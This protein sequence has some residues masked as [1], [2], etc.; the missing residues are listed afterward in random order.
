[1]KNSN[2]IHFFAFSR[3]APYHISIY[4]LAGK[5]IAMGRIATLFF[6]LNMR[7]IYH[8]Y[9]FLEFM[10]LNENHYLSFLMRPLV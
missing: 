2:K 9:I 8:T 5:L 7:D 1:M 4:E 3:S 6:L 10:E